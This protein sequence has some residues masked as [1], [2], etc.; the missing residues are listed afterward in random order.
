MCQRLTGRSRNFGAVHARDFPRLLRLADR[1]SGAID[2]CPGKITIFSFDKEQLCPTGDFRTARR[3]GG[4][5]WTN[6]RRLLHIP[7]KSNGTE[8][9]DVGRRRSARARYNATGLFLPSG[10][11][12]AAGHSTVD[13]RLEFAGAC[14]ELRGKRSRQLRHKQ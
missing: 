5:F 1:V 2:H 11:S 9:C 13:R 3:G 7:W 8:S 4:S 6:S 12:F 10:E 14:P